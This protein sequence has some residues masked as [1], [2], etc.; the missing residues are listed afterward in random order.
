ME[1]ASTSECMALFFNAFMRIS[2]PTSTRVR[3]II[4]KTEV[5]ILLDSGAT[6][7]FISPS[8]LAALHIT[9]RALPN[10]NIALG[11]GVSVQGIGVCP[12]VSFTIDDLAFTSDLSPWS[13]AHSTSF[14]GF[15]G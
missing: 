1:Q 13:W 8:I 12:T 10:L 7:N 2:K 4:N 6:H 11:T 14:W 15:N 3:G 9:S 5:V